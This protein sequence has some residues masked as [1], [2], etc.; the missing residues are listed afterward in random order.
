MSIT[1]ENNLNQFS[2]NIRY[3]RSEKSIYVHLKCF[4]LEPE[5]NINPGETNLDTRKYP[6]TGQTFFQNHCR[7]TKCLGFLK[8]NH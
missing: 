7:T 5:S 8:Q 4:P 6:K 2:H 1:V 3:K